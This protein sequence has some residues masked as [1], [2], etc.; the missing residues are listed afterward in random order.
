MGV[1]NSQGRS[2]AKPLVKMDYIDFDL[3]SGMV[4]V[5][6]FCHQNPN[7]LIPLFLF[8]FE[9]LPRISLLNPY[10]RGLFIS[11]FKGKIDL[12]DVIGRPLSSVEDPAARSC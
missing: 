9:L 11:G 10:L 6:F 7:M 8:V 4:V 5:L 12:Q 1:I 2:E 3:V